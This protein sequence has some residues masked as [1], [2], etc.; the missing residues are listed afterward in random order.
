M[1]PGALV[2]FSSA[3]ITAGSKQLEMCLVAE[4]VPTVPKAMES[5]LGNPK[6]YFTV[7]VNV[8]PMSV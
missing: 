4:H 2:I 7:C 5:N 3:G 1:C 6:S 8:V